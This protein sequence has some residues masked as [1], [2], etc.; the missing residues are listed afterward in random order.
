MDASLTS[1]MCVCAGVF[2]LFGL[3]QG[4]QGYASKQLHPLGF[5]LVTS[6][7]FRWSCGYKTA[8]QT[9]RRTIKW[10]SFFQFVRMCVEVGN[11]FKCLLNWQ[12]NGFFNL[13]SEVKIK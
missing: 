8:G 4:Q 5:F 1:G 10:A 11:W 3:G 9:D 12:Q 13:D 7:I 2:A 6:V